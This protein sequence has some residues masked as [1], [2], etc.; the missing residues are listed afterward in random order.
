MKFLDLTKVYIRSGSG[1][2]G[3]VSF[4]REKFIEYGGPDGGDGGHGGSVWAEAVEGLNTLIDFRYQQHFFADNGRPGMGSQRSGANGE[5]KVLYVP[6]GTEILDEDQE[7]LIADLTAVG[8]R[9]LLAKGGN[10]GFGNLHFKSSTNQAPRRANPG[11]EGI[12]RTLWLRLKLIA[13]AGLLG[14]PNAGKS[15]FLAAT[16]NAR[17]KIADYP[18]TTLH[19][20]LG[21]VGIDNAEYVVADIPGLIEGASEGRGIGDRFLGHVERCAVLL[22]LIDGTSDTV[23]EDYK[24]IIGELEAYGGELAAKDRVTVL[25]KIDALDDE[26]RA[27]LKADLEKAVGGP[28]MLMSGVSREGLD[29]VLRKVRAEIE[30][31]RARERAAGAEEEPW[32][33]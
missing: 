8:D 28:V 6:V 24:T 27:D 30:A 29:A 21:V 14:L 23:V 33:P 18:F 20:N 22:H 7:T 11:L 16:S 26:E 12:E 32:R 17:P 3:A 2:G 4:R 1:G 5:D 31:D 10:G 15:T 13:D 25:N 19:P 9:V